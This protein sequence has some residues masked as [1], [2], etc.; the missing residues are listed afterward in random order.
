MNNRAPHPDELH[1]YVD[2]QLPAERRAA[3]EAWLAANPD[4]AA[5]V[6]GWKADA[7][8]LRSAWGNATALSPEPR[9]DPARIR[10]H[11]RAN[12]WTGLAR[13][14]VLVMVLGLG[15]AGGWWARDARDGHA[16]PPMADAVTAYR[17]L[18]DQQVP[19]DFEG[20]RM[21][22]LQG[23]LARNFSEAGRVPDLTSQGYA[24]QG[25]RM[26]STPEGAAAMLVYEDGQGGMLGVYL[27]PRTQRMSEGQRRDG[28][29]MARYWAQGDTAIAV[30][31]SRFDE[32]AGDVAPL[33][34]RGG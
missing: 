1:A 9:L 17:L 33:M 2:G 30:V 22:G 20:D 25:A 26:L 5:R 28:G 16:N 12:R 7:E 8:A 32:R 23:W 18:A 6:R 27:R 31:S 14:A 11:L 29:L 24:L 10:R 19:M 21:G 3:V 15:G 34:R 4:D 13:A